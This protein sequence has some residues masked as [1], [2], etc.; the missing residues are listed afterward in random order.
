M[1]DALGVGDGVAVGEGLGVADGL[2]EGVPPPDPPQPRV[3]TSDKLA[4]IS[5]KRRSFAHTNFGTVV[6]FSE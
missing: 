2:G 1:G 3:A 4:V 6:P 5:D